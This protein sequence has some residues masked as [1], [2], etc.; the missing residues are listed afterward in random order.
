MS[1]VNI[2]F[3]ASKNLYLSNSSLERISNYKA[4]EKLKS[5]LGN[6]QRCIKFM[7]VYDRIR[8]IQF[9]SKIFYPILF[10]VY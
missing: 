10:R 2:C 4:E 7:I 1:E 5:K 9:T 3:I 8:F 6:K